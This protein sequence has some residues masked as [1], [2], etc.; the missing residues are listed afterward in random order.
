MHNSMKLLQKLAHH[1]AFHTLPPFSSPATPFFSTTSGLGTSWIPTKISRLAQL[2]PGSYFTF[3]PEGSSLLN[4]IVSS[5]VPLLVT[6]LTWGF[7]WL[8]SFSRKL[9]ADLQNITSEISH[10]LYF[11]YSLHVMQI[12][13]R[14]VFE[15]HFKI[16]TS[17]INNEHFTVLVTALVQNASVV[18]YDH[19][20][21]RKNEVKYSYKSWEYIVLREKY[22]VRTQIECLD[23]V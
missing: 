14:E 3:L 21:T 5:S 22:N 9:I 12:L 19:G 8:N 4:A 18:K 15:K 23:L 10:A 20:T 13:I 11:V 2:R 17:G 6:V 1:I 16:R 7:L